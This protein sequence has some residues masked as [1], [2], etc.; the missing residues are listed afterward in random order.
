MNMIQVQYMCIY[1]YKKD[2][3]LIIYMLIKTLKD[4]KV[5]IYAY[6]VIICFF[7]SSTFFCFYFV[8]FLYCKYVCMHVC[9]CVCVYTFP[10]E[11]RHT[12]VTVHV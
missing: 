10:C 6:E 2:I 3:K 11:F 1:V 9:V 5:G 7:L 12:C 8:L 4:K